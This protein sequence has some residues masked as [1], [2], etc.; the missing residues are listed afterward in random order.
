[1]ASA[2]SALTGLELV[3]LHGSMAFDLG[4]PEIQRQTNAEDVIQNVSTGPVHFA[5]GA[6]GKNIEKTPGNPQN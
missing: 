3:I 4:I 6:T 5:H 2:L 1:M